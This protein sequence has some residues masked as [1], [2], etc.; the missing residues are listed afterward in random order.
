MQRK[1]LAA[2]LWHKHGLGTVTLTPYA[3][4]A[5][6]YFCFTATKWDESRKLVSVY[7]IIYRI[8]LQIQACKRRKVLFNGL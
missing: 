5:R 6:A 8:C 2:V 1:V 4:T 7:E 3:S